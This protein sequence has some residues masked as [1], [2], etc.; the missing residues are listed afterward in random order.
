MSRA[1]HRVA[2]DGGFL[3]ALSSGHGD[4]AIVLLHG[5]PQT[6]REWDRV[7][8]L[9]DG[10]YRLVAPDLRG[11][12]DS[13]KPIAGYDAS[14]QADD[15]LALVRHFGLR[16]V[17][18]AGHDVGAHRRCPWPPSC[19]AFHRRCAARSKSWTGPERSPLRLA[20]AEAP[21]K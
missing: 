11:C 18:L 13:S 3:H 2:F 14:T 17:H 9:L 21:F 12:G 1:S 20:I 6:C 5:W 8:A 4:E 15:I 19:A 7:S 10:D 16:R